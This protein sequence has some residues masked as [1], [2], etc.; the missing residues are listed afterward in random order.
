MKI[1]R[2]VLVAVSAVGVLAALSACEIVVDEPAKHP[3][4]PPPPAAAATAATPA[5]APKEVKVAPM[6]LHGPGAAPAGG[7]TAPPPAGACLDTGAATVGD[8]AAMQPATACTA[9]P[10]PTQRCNAY[11]TYFAP[12]VAAAAVSC[13]TALSSAQLCDGTSVA[14]CGKT[15][16]TQAC[17]APGVAQLCQIAAGPCKTTATDC[18]AMLSGLGDQGQQAVAQCV[19]TGCTSG[20][21]ACI[22]G[23]AGTPA[24]VSSK[25]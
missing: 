3:T 19:A 1:D 14:A 24:A 20:L 23:L 2:S 12:K 10:T 21:T 8:C 22:D 18:T 13:V 15:A 6:H 4:P 16:L 9:T 11:K 7:G 25:H 5:P 17:P